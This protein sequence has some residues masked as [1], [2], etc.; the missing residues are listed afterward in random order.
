MPFP[1]VIHRLPLTQ[2]EGTPLRQPSALLFSASMRLA[3]LMLDDRPDACR[4]SLD[5]Q[6]ADD[7]GS[8]NCRPGENHGT[9]NYDGGHGGYSDDNGFSAHDTLPD[10][11]CREPQLRNTCARSAVRSD[12]WHPRGTTRLDVRL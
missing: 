9:G 11:N 12:S 3:G 10:Q 4:N 5:R 7:E 1:R 8:C 2:L 6:R